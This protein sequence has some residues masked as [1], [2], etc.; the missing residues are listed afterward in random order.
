MEVAQQ[1]VTASLGWG[2][3]LKIVFASGLV[4]ALI[5]L[6]KDFFFRH[7]DRLLD[8]KFSAIEAIAKLDLYALNSRSNIRNYHEQSASLS[9]E[10]DYQQW[11]CCSY[12]DLEISTEVLK[13]LEAEHASDIAWLSTEK[14]LA[15]EHLHAIYD[16]SFDPTEVYDHQAEV[17]GFFGYEAY[18]LAEKLRSKYELKSFGERWGVNDGFPDL[19]NAWEET[20]KEIAK[21]DMSQDL[22]ID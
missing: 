17:V 1:V 16:A 19:K 7:R 3:I 8:A 5:G 13:K 4:A 14:A 12:P 15:G 20:K 9:P 2:D 6:A 10:N 21:R 18:L 22:S 11:P